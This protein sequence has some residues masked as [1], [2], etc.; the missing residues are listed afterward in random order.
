MTLFF[1]TQ[2]VFSLKFLA[3]SFSYFIVFCETFKQ[4]LSCA[5]YSYLERKD[6]EEEKNKK[7][8]EK[9]KEEKETG[10]KKNTKNSL[11]TLDMQVYVYLEK[12]AH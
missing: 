3:I 11:H 9:K 8:K 1:S 4:P 10:Q 5:F 7:E 6:L 12:I 2:K